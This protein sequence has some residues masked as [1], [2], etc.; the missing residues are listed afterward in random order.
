MLL[1]KEFNSTRIKRTF[2]NPVAVRR[3]GPMN[4]WGL[5]IKNRCSELWI[6]EYCLVGASRAWFNTLKSKQEGN[7]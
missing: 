1:Y 7:S 4:A 5:V 3:D 2:G 6:P